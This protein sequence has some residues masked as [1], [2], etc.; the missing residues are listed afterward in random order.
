MSEVIAV[1]VGYI[2]GWTS[3]AL[4][5]WSDA[6]LYRRLLVEYETDFRRWKTHASYFGTFDVNTF[7][8]V[9]GPFAGQNCFQVMNGLGRPAPV[10]PS[11]LE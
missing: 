5:D 11:C 8:Y 7:T 3:K 2:V 9:L 4:L 10:K 6:D 1:I